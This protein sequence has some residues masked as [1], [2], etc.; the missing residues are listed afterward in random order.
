[1]KLPHMLFKNCLLISAAFLMYLPVVSFAQY[2]PLKE[3]NKT[4][5]GTSGDYLYSIKQTKDQGYILGGFSY[6]DLSGNRS[7]QTR[8]A[9]DYWVVK[10]DSI[11]NKKWD[12][13]FG[14]ASNDDLHVVNQ[15][16]DGGYIL[17]GYS[18]S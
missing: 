4:F 8:G 14:G 16:A 7:Q 18:E 9:G 1:M 17:G 6:S 12:K 2:A 3:W 5:G 11:G 13:A 10:I 15:D